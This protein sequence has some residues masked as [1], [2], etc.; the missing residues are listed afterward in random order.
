LKTSQADQID[1]GLRALLAL[2]ARHA[3]PFET[4]EN[5]GAHR[6]PRKQREVLEH[7]AAIRPRGGHRLALHHDASDLG[8][9]EPSDQIEQGGF[10]AAGRAEQRQEFARAHVERNLRQR[11]H[12]PTARR[13]IGMVHPLDDDL[14]LAVHGWDLL[15]YAAR[16]GRRA[17]LPEP[18]SAPSAD[19]A[20]C[21]GPDPRLLEFAE[22]SYISAK[23]KLGIVQARTP[24]SNARS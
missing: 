24:S 17:P 18:C 4:V 13:A 1:E 23:R 5:V 7:D 11:Q 20:G 22:N 6:F 9:E 8:R 12:R 19:A 21:P 2:G 14:A 15:Y 3:L 10:A 16:L